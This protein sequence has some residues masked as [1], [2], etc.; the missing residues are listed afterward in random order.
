MCKKTV[1]MMGEGKQAKE[2]AG[3]CL[4]DIDL[5]RRRAT[6]GTSSVCVI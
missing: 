6:A 4:E 1:G 5:I 2:N 3:S